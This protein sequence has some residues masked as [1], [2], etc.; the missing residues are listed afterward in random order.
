MYKD[1]VYVPSGE[2]AEYPRGI[3]LYVY[4]F[5]NYNTGKMYLKVPYDGHEN[6]QSKIITNIYLGIYMYQ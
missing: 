3:W 2:G 6:D 4:T 1:M 5:W